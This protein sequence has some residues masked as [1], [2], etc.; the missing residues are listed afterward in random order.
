MTKIRLDEDQR[1]VLRYLNDFLPANDGWVHVVE[2]QS[3]T[4]WP[5]RPPLD[6]LYKRGLVEWRGYRDLTTRDWR[7]TDAGREAIS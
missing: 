3:A 6:S 1:K 4:V 7:I 2:L 5:I